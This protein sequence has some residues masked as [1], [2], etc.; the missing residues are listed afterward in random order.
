[1]KKILSLALTLAMVSS[2]LTAA[3]AKNY[4][5]AA[6]ITY[7]EA[8]EV[9]SAI[10]VLE[11]DGDGFRPEDTLKRSEAA[12]IICALNLTP[13]TAASLSAGSAPFADVPVSHWA[14]GYIAEGVQSGILAG[15]GA[16][17]FAP[18]GQ[19]TGYQYLK[20]LLVSLGYD[21]E[22]EGLVGSNWAMNVA[23]LAKKTGLTRGNEDFVGTAPVKREEA[24]LYA[25]NTLQA[26]RVEYDNLGTDIIVNGVIISTGASAAEGTGEAYM[27]E[28]YSKL[29]Q[30]SET[31]QYGRPATEW[32]YKGDLVG[33]YSDAPILTITESTEKE[34]V[35]DALEDEGYAEKDFEATVSA[36]EN[37]TRVEFFGEE[38]EDEK[39]RVYNALTKV[40]SIETYAA[41][42]G[43]ITKD[44]SSTEADERTMAIGSYGTITADTEKNKSAVEVENFDE[45][46]KELER[47][48]IVL[49]TLNTKGDIATVTIPET[50]EGKVN[51]APSAKSPKVTVDGEVYE[52]SANNIGEYPVKSTLTVYL[53]DYGYA[54]ASGEVKNETSDVVYLT[55]TYKTTDK[56]GNESWYAQ[57]VT[58][59]GEVEELPLAKDFKDAAVNKAYT[60]AT[61]S[62]GEIELDDASDA[63]AL[64]AGGEL[65]DNSYVR[66][67]GKRYYFAESLTMVY[68][69][70]SGAKLTVSVSDELEKIAEIPAGSF[71]VVNEDREIITL[72]IAGEAF[73]SSDDLIYIADNT[74]I[75]DDESGS[76]IEAYVNGELTEIIVNKT[77]AAGFYTASVNDDDVYAL[78]AVK[79]T[80][81]STVTDIFRDKYMTLAGLEADFVLAD[82]AAIIDLS[83][84]AISDLADLADAMADGLAIRATVVFDKGE[85]T[86]TMM[87]IETVEES[88]E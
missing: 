66:I 6:D 60:Y 10:G 78:T 54:I 13:K 80:A 84:N 69:D 1:M 81:I 48:D 2:M 14:S 70:G 36:V 67:G 15:V 68:V 23:K 57:I 55:D 5:D 82:D 25:L 39:G 21:A 87:V 49:V 20:M 63:L 76:V 44:K 19:L 33:L 46:Y 17:Q 37:G 8:V 53:D 65:G 77:Y 58:A 75:A 40:V 74:V 34:D 12:K 47:G 64:T 52:L 22:A 9:L 86:V 3:Q 50:V 29:R 26:E 7:T 32:T 41:K 27:K 16:N 18:D 4:D 72:F 11:G 28:N 59:A 24:A 71:A 31:D 42:V 43:T 30:R 51:R 56:Y 61:N 38:K 83:D 85:E 35:I 79:A 45:L 73:V 88:K 62:D